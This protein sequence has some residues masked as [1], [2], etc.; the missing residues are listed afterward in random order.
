MP[1]NTQTSPCADHA[2][3]ATPQR[4]DSVLGWLRAIADWISETRRLHTSACQLRAM[5]EH[6]LR[7]LGLCR[8][9]IEDVVRGRTGRR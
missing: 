9:D 4:P 2:L 7:D 6:M 8:G 1:I 3:S 5:D